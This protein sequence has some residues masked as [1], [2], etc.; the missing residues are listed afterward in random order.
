[1]H[2]QRRQTLLALAQPRQSIGPKVRGGVCGRF[3]RVEHEPVRNVVVPKE[4]HC[5]AG[6]WKKYAPA[7]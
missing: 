3:G 2:L 7:R 6:S 1:M 4:L 5:A